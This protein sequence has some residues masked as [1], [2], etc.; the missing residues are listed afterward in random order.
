MSEENYSCP[1]AMAHF[2]KY[3]MLKN[4][5]LSMV[6]TIDHPFRIPGINI[7]SPAGMVCELWRQFTGNGSWEGNMFKYSSFRGATSFANQSIPMKIVDD[8]APDKSN[9]AFAVHPLRSLLL[10][11]K[12]SPDHFE[13]ILLSLDDFEFVPP[14][15]LIKKVVTDTKLHKWIVKAN[16]LK[17]GQIY[18]QIEV[19]MEANSEQEMKIKFYKQYASA[20]ITQITPFDSK[21]PEI[22]TVF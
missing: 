19:P 14:E 11:G 5:G 10:F 16:F 8:F 17:D 12:N 18:G 13:K 7:Y 22:Y 2:L 6:Q 20:Y 3:Q 15:H 9:T 1:T 4:I 21:H